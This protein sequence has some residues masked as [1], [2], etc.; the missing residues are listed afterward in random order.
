M[1]WMLEQTE[2]R[3]PVTYTSRSG[4]L[5]AWY[6]NTQ[7]CLMYGDSAWKKWNS[8]FQ[9]ELVAV[10]NS[11][12][13]WAQPGGHDL[14]NFSTGRSATVYNTTLSILMLEVFYRYMPTTQ[15]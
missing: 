9:N 13:S 10:H 12:G 5:Y 7:A 8:W 3:Y 2:K 15:G 4:D 11:D 14:G 6:Y 1:E